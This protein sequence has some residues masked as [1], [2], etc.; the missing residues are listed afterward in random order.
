MVI[1]NSKEVGVAMAILILSCPIILAQGPTVEWVR[2]YGGFDDE[3]GYS[4]E[5]TSDGGYVIGG[6][7]CSYGNGYFEVPDA[8]I[9]KVN[10][11]GDTLWTRTYGIQGEDDCFSV[12]EM[13]DGDYMA[14]IWG[15]TDLISLDR[16][17]DS[18]WSTWCNSLTN[19]MEIT[20]DGGFILS[21]QRDTGFILTKTDSQGNI[22]WHRSYSFPGTNGMVRSV[23]PVND[24]G[25]L[26]AGCTG[27]P[28][29]SNYTHCYLI[30]TDA[31]G[32]TL[33]TRKYNHAN[34]TYEEG[35][36]VCQT[37]DGGFLVLCNDFWVIKTD[38][39]GNAEW[40]QFCD[41]SYGVLAFS[42]SPLD[43]GTYLVSGAG[44]NPSHNFLMS[45]IDANGNILWIGGYGEEL[46]WGWM[47]RQTSDGGY[48]MVGSAMPNEVTSD[49]RLVKFSP[50]EGIGDPELTPHAVELYQNNPNPF[51]SSTLIS[52]H[53][54]EPGAVNLDIYDLL[55]RKITSLSE[56][57]QS[58][59]EHQAIWEASAF[60]SGIYFARL[61]TSGYSRSIK[62]T[63]LK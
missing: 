49:I 48:I 35:V 59:G 4:V 22:I 54:S 42:I 61:K 27:R 56:G 24:G 19:H 33:W 63:L 31:D 41:S 12:K 25:F 29:D 23:I 60:P 53:I 30:R 13:P 16:N 20:S 50:L 7:T 1:R 46:S 55:G 38:P 45:K 39:S 8:Y 17:G 28:P 58:A 18:L 5:Q 62:I 40:T 9:V 14:A 15:F 43:D 44:S 52:Y 26:A 36:G 51:N 34:P 37:P 57:V 2:D 6:A 11:V 21:G 47:A 10:S 32:D 3:L